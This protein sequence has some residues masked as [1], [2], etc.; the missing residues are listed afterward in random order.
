[1]TITG[2]MG[3]GRT[4]RDPDSDLDA[5]ENPI[6]VPAFELASCQ[7]S[8]AFERTLVSLDQSLMS[9]I[10]TSLS[11]IGFGFVMVV[12]INQ[13]S[14]EVGVNLRIPARNFGFSLV[15]MGVGL[16]SIGLVGHRRRFTALKVRMDRLYE[17]KLLLER[18]PYRSAPVAVLATLLLLC[19]ILVM[20]AILVR[21]GPFG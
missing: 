18:C 21:V 8:L 12:F 7:A 17:R 15:A 13:V 3:L 14:G 4:D 16:I 5:G 6:N 9:A 1:M 20:L 2:Q 11:L 19:G 10:R